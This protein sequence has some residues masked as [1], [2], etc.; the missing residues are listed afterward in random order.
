LYAKTRRTAYDTTGTLTR[1]FMYDSTLALVETSSVAQRRY[2][3]GSTAYGDTVMCFVS[4]DFNGGARIMYFDNAFHEIGMDPGFVNFNT[5][6]IDLGSFIPQGYSYSMPRFMYSGSRNI[7]AIEYFDF[8]GSGVPVVLFI[9]RRAR[10]IARMPYNNKQGYDLY[11][12]Q[13]GD[14]YC[15][16]SGSQNTILKF[17]TSGLFAPVAQ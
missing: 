11:F 4:D 15:V 10:V 7:F 3:N 13:A 2:I 8:M 12:D 17:S 16:S 5:R 1:I 9:D 6:F 14:C